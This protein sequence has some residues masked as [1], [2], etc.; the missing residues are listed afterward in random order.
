MKR[1]K[2]IKYLSENGCYLSREG[3]NHSVFVNQRNNNISVVPRHPD[4]ND[5]LAVKICK[6]LD[7]PKITSH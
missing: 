5:I 7:I 4:I 6:D 3:S 1:T 2:F